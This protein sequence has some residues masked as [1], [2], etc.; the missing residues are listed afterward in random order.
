ICE[1]DFSA[2][3]IDQFVQHSG[4]S[5]PGNLVQNLVSNAQ[6]HVEE[7]GDY[8]WNNFRQELIQ[9]YRWRWEGF[10]K[11]LSDRLHSDDKKLIV[12]NAWCSEPFEA[13]YR[14]GID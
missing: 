12:N 14:F 10:F 9:F 13:I 8:I 11:K 4:C 1:G 2:D 6:V 3:I 7:R 5:L